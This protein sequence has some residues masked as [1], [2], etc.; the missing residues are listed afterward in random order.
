PD[1]G[2]LVTGELHPDAESVAQQVV[3]ERGARLVRA[4]ASTGEP[5]RA[6]GAFQ[7][8]HFALARAAAEAFLGSL[9]ERAVARAA[10]EVEIPG[11]LQAV[12]RDPLVLYDGAHNPAGAEAL[13][14]A[15][16]E[17][18]GSRPLVAAIGVLDDKDAAGMLRALLPLCSRVVFP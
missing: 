14:A 8:S 1:G 2:C 3:A 5:L 6:L 13:A 10:A 18:V 9:D 17:I 4:G 15:L 16:P 7:R 12:G 11:R